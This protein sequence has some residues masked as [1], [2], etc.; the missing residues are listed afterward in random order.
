[1]L[2]KNLGKTLREFQATHD[3][4][5]VRK[6]IDDHDQCDQEAEFV[7]F[8]CEEY[9]RPRDTPLDQLPR[10]GKGHLLAKGTQRNILV[11]CP[12]HGEQLFLH[13]GNHISVKC[14][15]SRQCLRR[16]ST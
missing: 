1:M 2:E 10:T 12:I 14:R 4:A 5:A 8:I 9:V 15:R 6:W 16:S 3:E 11:R 13:H 7:E